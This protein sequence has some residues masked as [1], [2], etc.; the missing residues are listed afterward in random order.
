MRMMDFKSS[1]VARMVKQHPELQF[2][3]TPKPSMSMFGDT[4]PSMMSAGLGNKI[5]Q[6][7][8]SIMNANT[9]KNSSTMKAMKFMNERLGG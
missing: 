5:G 9:V 4:S 7:K 2:I 3:S 6:A 1:A 8:P